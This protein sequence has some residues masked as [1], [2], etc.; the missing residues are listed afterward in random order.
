MSPGQPQK[1]YLYESPEY[2]AASL[3]LPQSMAQPSMVTYRSVGIGIFGA[4]MRLI[5]MPLEKIAL[6]MNSSQ[7]AGKGQFAQAV[8]LTFQEGYLAPYRVVGKASMT[9]WFLQYS[10]MGVAFNSSTTVSAS[11]S[12]SNRSGTARNSWNL[13]SRKIALSTTKFV[14]H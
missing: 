4:T 12:A 14:P 13:P 1:Q 9:A 3:G 11:S 6:F 10:V 8:K 5:G 7:V 2:V